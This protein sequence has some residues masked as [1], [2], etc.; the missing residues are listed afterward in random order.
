MDFW[1]LSRQWSTY[2]HTSLDKSF[3]MHTNYSA[4]TCLFIFKNVK[5]RQPT[6]S[7]VSRGTV[8]HPSITS[9][10]NTPTQMLSP[11][12]HVK[13]KALTV[14]KSNNKEVA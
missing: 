1:L 9:D 3:K 14:M 7:R 6:G 4:L 2:T 11:E 13:G 10:G 8:S 5:D 12:D